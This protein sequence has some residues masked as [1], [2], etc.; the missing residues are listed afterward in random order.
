MLCCVEPA[1]PITCM[2]YLPAG[3][4]PAA[5]GTLLLIEALEQATCN[6]QPTAIRARRMELPTFPRLG[7]PSTSG[8]SSIAVSAS[9]LA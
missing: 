2:L 5:L 7:L 9:P 6:K 1:V 4:P 3:V 8:A